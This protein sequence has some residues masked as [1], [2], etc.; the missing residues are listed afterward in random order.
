MWSAAVIVD[1]DSVCVLVETWGAGQKGSEHEGPAAER[2]PL[3]QTSPG[4]ALGY[5]VCRA[6]PYWQH[7]LD[8]LHRLR[9]RYEQGFEV[10]TGQMDT[11]E[12]CYLKWYKCHFQHV[13]Q[14]V[15]A[16]TSTIDAGSQTSFLFMLQS[17]HKEN[18]CI[19]FHLN[20]P[21]TTA[22]IHVGPRI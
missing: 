10:D 14:T 5:R 17:K 11:V 8:H 6:R 7:G 19:C 22:P 13:T 3:P 20:Q 2:A 16:V 15:K 1:I 18:N 9:T 4:A 12:N 21:L